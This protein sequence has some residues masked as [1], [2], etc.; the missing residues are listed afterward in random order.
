MNA[1]HRE[2]EPEPDPSAADVSAQIV[3]HRTVEYRGPV[4]HPRV[5]AEFDEV[6]PGSATIIFQEWQE[7]QTLRRM[8]QSDS[9]ENVNH[10]LKWAP[11]YRLIT[12]IVVIAGGLIA[13]LLDEPAMGWFLGF[14][15]AVGYP[16]SNALLQYLRKRERNST[17]SDTTDPET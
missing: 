2:S 3:A 5:L 11:L 12:I 14:G 9:S 4:P 7:D 1:D 16:A 6:V 15:A 10:A 17:S 13:V 8:L